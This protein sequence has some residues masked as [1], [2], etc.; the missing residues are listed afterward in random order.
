MTSHGRNR[1]KRRNSSGSRQI[2]C[3]RARSVRRCPSATRSN[4]ARICAR[5]VA[6]RVG[7]TV[8]AAVGVGR[9]RAFVRLD[10]TWRTAPFRVGTRPALASVWMYSSTAAG[11][12]PSAR[13]R[14]RSIRCAGD[15]VTPGV[16]SYPRPRCSPCATS[17][18]P[19][20]FASSTSMAP[21]MILISVTSGMVASYQA[22]HLSGVS[23]ARSSRAWARWSVSRAVSI[24]M[25]FSSLAVIGPPCRIQGRAMDERTDGPSDS[26]A[27][28]LASFA[29]VTSQI[30]VR[31]SVPGT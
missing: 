28:K 2:A 14:A 7:S 30:R 4:V 19:R 5:W 25:R 15:D 26:S 17:S 3:R 1:T 20:R 11:F 29:P 13:S 12:R 8:T 23:V 16:T 10:F 6:S 31:I 18:W 22:V 27:K 9:R 24:K 21:A